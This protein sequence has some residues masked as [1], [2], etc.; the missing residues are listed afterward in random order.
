MS[1]TDRCLVAC[2]AEVD[3]GGHPSPSDLT[4]G[5]VVS[6]AQMSVS[7]HRELRG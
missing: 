6:T 1:H 7:L 3:L 5:F 2:V 4:G